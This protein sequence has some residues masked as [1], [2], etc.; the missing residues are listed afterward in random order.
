MSLSNSK[1]REHIRNFNFKPLFVEL[2]WD[3][4]PGNQSFSVQFDNTNFQFQTLTQ[5]SGFQVFLHVAE[6]GDQVPDRQTGLKLENKLTPLAAEH[7]VIFTDKQKTRQVWQWSKREA[8]SPPRISRDEY[9]TGGVG[10]RLAQKLGK[11]SFSLAEE[12]TGISITDVTR[13]NDAQFRERVTKRFYDEFKKQHEAF[14]KKIEGISELANRDWYASLTLNR[15]MFVYFIQHKGFLESN[16]KYLRAKLDETRT[17]IGDD[18]FYS[19][20]KTFLVRFFHNGLGEPNHSPELISIIGKIPYLNGGLFERHEIEINN[21]I[22]IQDKAFEDIFD[23]FDKYD[24]HL[25]DRP[26]RDDNEINPDVLGYIFEKF[27]NQ[28][29]MGAYYTKEDITDYISKNTIVPFLFDRVKQKVSIAFDRYDGVWKILRDNP[30]RYI[31]DAVKKGVIDEDG[32]ET[33]IPEEIAEGLE[34]VSKRANWNRTADEKFGLPTE[35]WREYAARRQRCLEI[36]RKMQGGEIYDINDL[37]TYNLDITKFAEDVIFTTESSDFVKAFYHAIAGRIP[38]S[39]YEKLEQGITVL[40]PT[41]GSGAFL[42]AALKILEPLL[43][44]CLDRMEDFIEDENLLRPDSVKFAVFRRV[45]DENEKHPNRAYF[46]LKSIIVNNLFGVDIMPDAVEICKLRLFLTLV[47]QVDADVNKRNYGLEPLPDIDF[48][49]R[50]GNTL[51]GFA[52]EKEVYQAFQGVTQARLA[53]DDRADDFKWKAEETAKIYEHFRLQQIKEGGEIKPEDKAN[54]QTKLRELSGELDKFIAHE[55]GIDEIKK[56]RQFADFLQSH[57]PFHWYSEFF[58]IIADGG[59]DV[60]IG[61]PPY[62]SMSKVRKKY[63][64]KNYLTHDSSDVYA[65][66]LERCS[67]L[68]VN[69]GRFG[70]IVPLSVTFSGDFDSLRKLLYSSYSCNWFSSFARIPAALFNFDVRVRNTIHLGYKS[71][72][73]EKLN[74]TSVLHRWFEEARPNLFPNLSYSKFDTKPFE[75]LIP[76][77]NTPKF[78]EILEKCIERNSKKLNTSFSRQATEHRLYFKKTAYNW[79]NFCREMPPCYD[80]AGNLIPHTQFGELS[81]PSAEIRDL[82]FLFLNGKLQFTFWAIIGDD[83]HVANWMFGNFPIDLDNLPQTTKQKLL[84]LVNE[85]EGLMI[86]NTSFKLNAGKRIGNYNLAKCRVVTDKSDLMF[87][88][89]LQLLDVWGDIELL[90]SQIVKTNFELLDAE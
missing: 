62:L 33:E 65:P 66:T 14:A 49:I 90:Y 22:N 67:N 36:R 85:L 40:D 76:K 83:F 30:D 56:P 63:A 3:A 18:M 6:S 13:R 9:R 69:G 41:C 5:K 29:Q 26:L 12:E 25:D 61:N 28:K 8:G 59:F 68:L 81:F 57:Q 34:D 7:L 55:Y 72:S 78:E 51:V 15:L 23:F 32:N 38:E 39:S 75:K 19:F 10:E 84:S 60:I 53:F 1:I 88:E 31:Y 17:T 73:S 20:Y 79:L 70:M 43:D 58:G 37:I 47:A 11:F 21:D 54:L 77:I 52:N 42:F 48:N 46:V 44:K 50:A 45:L 27:I 4:L 74:F 16:D 87:A 64:L 80:G 82:A 35:T 89:Y 86:R 2:G 71:N 24:W